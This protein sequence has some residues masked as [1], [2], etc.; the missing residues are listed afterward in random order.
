VQTFVDP[1]TH[2]PVLMPLLAMIFL[3]FVAGPLAHADP[4]A[5]R[6]VT[7]WSEG[8]P[9]VGD[10]WPAQDAASASAPAVLLVHGW[11][12]VRS[13]LNAV[14]APRF[15]AAGYAVLTFDYRGWGDS[16]G[17]LLRL[18]DE[19][20]EAREIV[21]PIAFLEDIRNALA[22]LVTEP[23]VDAERIGIWGTSLGGGLALQ[24]AA[25]HPDLVKALLIQ[26]GSVN[27]RSGVDQAGPRHP[28]S[29]ASLLQ[30]RARVARG[31]LPPVPGAESQAQGLRGA[32]D[33]LSYG[34]FDPFSAHDRVQAAT[35]IVDAE[36]EELFDI[37]RN[38]AALHA[39]LRERVPVRYEVLPGTHYDIYRGAA[40]AR[41]LELQIEWLAQHL[42]LERSPP[43]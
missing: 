2:G 12:G 40:L 31:D 9:L 39:A 29:P 37:A 4:Y 42:A 38:G 17:R 41:A 14:Y 34:R 36:Q 16:P 19:T 32:A 25:D 24:T 6:G 27:P 10:F 26:V 1:P 13:H 21:D 15:A 22:F 33:W 30:R 5:P 8:L 11:G 7:I 23:G 43:R 28:M 35:L 18:A 20:V 3:L